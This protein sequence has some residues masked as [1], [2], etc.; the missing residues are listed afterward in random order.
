MKVWEPLGND[1]KL[2][3]LPFLCYKGKFLY[4]RLYTA[5]GQFSD[6]GEDAEVWLMDAS[7]RINTFTAKIDHGRSI[8]L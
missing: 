7:C 6:L 8:T 2:V 5:E 1:T 3:S 4:Y